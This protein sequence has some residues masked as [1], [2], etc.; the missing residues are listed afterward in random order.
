MKKPPVMSRVFAN[1][2]RLL[3]ELATERRIFMP[4]GAMPDIVR[5]AFVSAEDRNFYTHKGVDPLAVAR[6]SVRYWPSSGKKRV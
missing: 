5:Q 6:A 2:G 4:I 3:A 1:D